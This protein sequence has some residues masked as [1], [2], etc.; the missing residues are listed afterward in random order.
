MAAP[1]HRHVE[2]GGEAERARVME[3]HQVGRAVEAAADALARFA[4]ELPVVGRDRALAAAQPVLKRAA[5]PPQ[6]GIGEQHAPLHRQAGPGGQRQ[7][8]TEQLRNR[9]GSPG[10]ADMQDARLAQGRRGI[11]KRLHRPAASQRGIVARSA[12]GDGHGLEVGGHARERTSGAGAPVAAVALRRAA[13]PPGPAPPVGNKGGPSGGA[14][15]KV[16]A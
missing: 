6:V 10:R 4:P 9:P 14:R 5:D 11:L 2:A 13:C 1:R 7:H 12:R 3:D 15:K 8:P 16:N